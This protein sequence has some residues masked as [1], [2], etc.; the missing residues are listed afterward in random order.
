MDLVADMLLGSLAID[1]SDRIEAFRVR[2]PMRRRFSRS[3]A[4]EGAGRISVNL[5]RGVNRF[6]DYPRLLRRTWSN[7]DLFHVVDHSYGQLVHALPPERTVVTCHD[8]HTFQCILDEGSPSRSLP[9]RRMTKRIL[10]GVVRARRVVFDTEAVRD[11]A[12]RLGLVRPE[13]TAIAPLG[14]HP[15]CSPDPDPQADAEARRLLAALP[16]GAIPLLHVGGTFRRKRIDLLL[17][18][19]AAVRSLLPEA[20]LVRV[21]GPLPPEQKRIARELA[22]EDAI[23][24]LPYL[25]REVLAAVYRASTLVLLPSEEEGFGLPVLEAL[26]CG[27]PVVA[28]DLPVLREVGGTAAV[29]RPVGQVAEWSAAVGALVGDGEDSES[30]REALRRAGLAQAA[31]FSWEEYGRRMVEIY[32]ALL[33]EGVEGDAN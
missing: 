2:P 13:R 14:V 16:A 27:T 26:A 4:D 24:E 5:D 11:D 15:S 20:R 3:A 19:F 32:E 6:W 22:V 21:G 30:R 17:R 33:E 7:F 18:I 23:L 25:S 31:R 28:S 10:D 12:L 29:F 9:F 8:L 1:H